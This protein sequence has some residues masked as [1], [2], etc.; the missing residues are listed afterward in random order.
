MARSD[1]L[2]DRGANLLDGEHALGQVPTYHEAGHSPDDGCGF[3]LGEDAT[4][5]SA[6][7]FCTVMPIS[8]H[9]GEHHAE[10][11]GTPQGSYGFEQYVGG[12]P[13]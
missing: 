4:A 6:D 8:A 2:E 11:A 1:D 13:T 9:S 10:R 3:V 5:R 12:W 7:L